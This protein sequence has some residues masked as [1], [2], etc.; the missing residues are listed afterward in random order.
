MLAL[1]DVVLILLAIGLGLAV[2]VRPQP[3]AAETRLMTALGEIRRQERRFPE[4]HQTWKQVRGYGQDLARLFPLLLETERFLAKPGL[5]AST[6]THLEARRNA[7]ADQL[8]RGTAFL[9]RL[10][11]EML[12]GLHEPP[13]LMEFPT[14]RLELG[15]VLHPD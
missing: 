7:L 13:A 9:E 2:L 8:E 4:L 15:E 6:R 12:L 14:L 11:A 1:L 5:D 10:G 3:S